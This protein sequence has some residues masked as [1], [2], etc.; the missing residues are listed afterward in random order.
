MYFERSFTDTFP[1]AMLCTL[2][3][4]L[5][6]R[7]FVRPTFGW[8][9]AFFSTLRCSASCGAAF[10]SLWFVLLFGGSA[11]ASNLRVEGG[12]VQG[13][14]LPLL[15]LTLVLHEKPGAVRL[16]RAGSHTGFVAH[17]L[18]NRVLGAEKAPSSARAA[19]RRSPLCRCTRLRVA[20]AV[21]RRTVAAALALLTSFERPTLAEPNYN[22]LFLLDAGRTH[23]ADARH[24]VLARPLSYV[25]KV[26]A[27]LVTFL[28]P[29]TRYH[30]H[31]RSPNGPHHAHRHVFGWFETVF[32]AVIHRFPLRAAGLYVLLPLPLAWAAKRARGLLRDGR[33]AVNAEA[34]VLAFCV[35]QICYLAA[36]STLRS[37]PNLRAS[38]TRSSR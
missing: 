37:P 27:T 12:R 15:V 2:A 7:A 14:A 1:A 21:F 25:R 13:R 26:L 10:T 4:A 36:V 35:A 33:P 32:D 29:S 17:A 30:P 34:I 5:L 20:R 6:H 23:R 8:W 19:S 16:F 28:G 31:N 9:T 18:T 3:T 22:H 38:A 11:R 24:V